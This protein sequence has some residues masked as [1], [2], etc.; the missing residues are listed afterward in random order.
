MK[1]ESD[2]WF[3]SVLLDFV[4]CFSAISATG[5]RISGNAMQHDNNQVHYLVLNF[6]AV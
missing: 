2:C 1:S 5:E 3:S 6:G 4:A